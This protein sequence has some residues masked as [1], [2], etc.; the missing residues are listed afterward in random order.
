MKKLIILTVIVTL[1][2]ACID[3]QTRCQ[4]AQGDYAKATKMIEQI[5]SEYHGAISLAE[6][7]QAFARMKPEIEKQVLAKQD[8]GDYCD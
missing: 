2:T 8:I 4:Q 3:R 7:E 1:L 6:T 5:Q